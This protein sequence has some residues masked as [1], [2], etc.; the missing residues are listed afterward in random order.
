MSLVQEYMPRV[1]G[2]LLGEKYDQKTREKVVSDK[3]VSGP[4][5]HQYERHQISEITGAQ[6]RGEE[7]GAIGT[8][9]LEVSNGHVCIRNP[10]FTLNAEDRGLQVSI[11][12]G[13]KRM[14]T[15]KR[16]PLNRLV[17][18][19][20]DSHQSPSRGTH[21]RRQ[22]SSLGPIA[23]RGSNFLGREPRRRRKDSKS[24][25]GEKSTY[26]GESVDK[27]EEDV[28]VSGW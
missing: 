8:P 24:S 4:R 23:R 20:Q 15:S 7:A 21:N 17:S 11:K 2:S 18:S 25:W 10:Y 13:R 14:K 26:F 19:G 5:D 6:L 22:L 27:G 12:Y 16:A 28:K 3:T 1:K 9:Q